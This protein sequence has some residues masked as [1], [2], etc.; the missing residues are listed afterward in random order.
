MT[1]TPSLDYIAL[2]DARFAA[3]L[4]SDNIIQPIESSA[5]PRTISYRA[6][7]EDGVASLDKGE[8]A[9]VGSAY[10]KIE[11]AGNYYFAIEADDSARLIIPAAGID[12]TK[13]SGKLNI[14]RAAVVTLEAGYYR[15][16]DIHVHNIDYSAGANAIAFKASMDTQPIPDGD[17]NGDSTFRRSFSTAPNMKLYALV[18]LGE[19]GIGRKEESDNSCKCGCS[20]KGGA[21]S[22]QASVGCARWDMNIGNFEDIAG[23]PNAQLRMRAF[24]LS[25]DELT[26]AALFLHHPMFSVLSVADGIATITRSSGDSVSYDVSTGLPTSGSGKHSSRSRLLDDRYAPLTEESPI[27]DAAYLEECFADS[28][29]LTY[30]IA[31]GQAERMLTSEQVLVTA[32]EWAARLELI[33]DV[34]DRLRQILDSTLGLLDITTSSATSYSIALYPTSQVGAKGLDGLYSTTGN[35]IKTST[36]NGV[37]DTSLSITE[38]EGQNPATH[39]NWT[40]DGNNWN[41]YRGTEN[42]GVDQAHAVQGLQPDLWRESDTWKDDEGN[43]IAATATTYRQAPYGQ[44]VVRETEGYGSEARHT[45]YHYGE[46]IEE[47][48]YG[49]LVRVDEPTGNYT[50]YEYDAEG[51]VVLAASPTA[52]SG[53]VE[54]GTR[55]TYAAISDRFNDHRPATVKDVLITASGTEVVMAIT[56]YSYEDSSSLHRVTISRSGTGVTGTRTTITESYGDSIGT[57]PAYARGQVKYEQN[58]LGIE[59]HHSYEASSAYGSVLKHTSETRISNAPVVGK[60][61]R[62]VEYLA[63]NRNVLRSETYAYTAANEWTLMSASTYSY[64]ERGRELSRTRS[65]GRVSTKTWMCCGLL[66]ETDEDGVTTLYNYDAAKRLIGTERSAT[67]TTP[68]TVTAYELD[69]ADRRI[70]TLVSVGARNTVTSKAYDTLGRVISETDVLGRVTDTAY[71]ADGLTTTTTMPAGATF[72]STVNPDGSMASESG[73]GQREIF[74]SYDINANRYRS[75]QK[76]SDN[77]VLSQSLTNTLG[78][79]VVEAAAT[80]SCFLYT[81]SEYNTLGQL[82]RRWQDSGSASRAATVYEYDAFGEISKETLLLDAGSPSDATKNLIRTL[83]SVYEKDAQNLVWKVRTQTRNNPA[84][85]WL[86]SSQRQ[87]VSE[88]ALLESSTSTTDERGQTST[89]TVAYDAQSSVT[90]LHTETIPTSNLPATATVVDGFTTSQTDHSGVTATYTRAFTSSGMTQ[91]STDGRGNTMTTLS[92]LADRIVCTTEAVNNTTTTTYD[93]YFDLPSVVTNAQG[94][95]TCYKYDLR[96]RKIAEWGTSIQ[97]ACFGYDDA[98]NLI[99]LTTF[100]VDTGDITTD[101]SERTDGDTTTWA[102]HPTAGVELSKTY[103]DNSQVTKTYNAFK[104]ISTET[105]ARGQVAT[106]YYEVSTGDLSSVFYNDGSTARLYTYNIL[107]QITQ[108]MD[109]SGLKNYS[110]NSYGQLTQETSIGFETGSAKEQT[111]TEIYDSLGRSTGYTLHTCNNEEQQVRIA[112]AADGRISSAGFMHGGVLKNFSYG[113]LTGTDLLHTLAH[114]NGITLTQSYETTRDLLTGMQYR[115]GQTDVASRSYTYDSL[116]RPTTRSTSRQG[117]V[118]NDTFTHNDR[119]ELT[120]TSLGTDAYSYSYDNIGNRKT[121]QED[122]EDAT[123]YTANNLNQYTS[124]QEGE[125]DPPFVPT[126]DADGNQTKVKTSTGIWTVTYNILNLPTSFIRTNGDGTQTKVTAAYDTYGRRVWKKVEQIAAD[127]LTST[128]QS[129][130]LFLYRGYLQIAALDLTTPSLQ[131]QHFILWDPS[132]PI[133]TRPLAIQKNATWYTYGWDLTKNVCEVFGPDGYL[134]TAYT[135]MP[136]GSVTANGNV[137]Q[138]LQWSSEYHDDTMDLV[139]FNYRFYNSKVGNWLSKDPQSSLNLYWYVGN[140]PIGYTDYLGR[141]YCISDF[142]RKIKLPRYKGAANAWPFCIDWDRGFSLEFCGDLKSGKIKG[143]FGYGFEVGITGGFMFRKRIW[144]YDIY[145][146]LGLRFFGGAS[147][148]VEI[149]GKYDWSSC[150][151]SI[152]ALAEGKV[153]LGAEIGAL[154]RVANRKGELVYE[155]GVG[156]KAT[157]NLQFGFSLE[158]VQQECHLKGYFRFSDTIDYSIFANFGW[159][160]VSHQGEIEVKK[161]EKKFL[162]DFYLPFELGRAC[163]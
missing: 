120:A 29:S 104:Q 96:G 133:A 5:G 149:E 47:P 4:I 31:G 68:A 125:L 41:W 159:F 118:K 69:S 112:Y 92:D 48:S 153:Y 45:D 6:Y 9:E 49:K 70:R 143:S 51:R 13:A 131:A 109:A 135:Y 84:G 78:D 17:Y 99:S 156:G 53:Y 27:S 63:S 39:W 140:H 81:K 37:L 11:T 98:D 73:T 7:V 90:R 26:P 132:Q 35:R 111:C 52:I 8:E 136:Y 20:C 89:R 42:V 138:P 38:Q 154:A 106:Y 22:T 145:G 126:Y 79:K 151:C 94:K 77:S 10:I 105:N 28:S 91:T 14:A 139:Y 44:V 161:T 36:F 130:Q 71:S 23:M 119:S 134:K 142:N 24:D 141:D 127:G 128:T 32:S 95:T 82:V 123:T 147:G 157:Y 117:T 113:Y 18:S 101:P 97:P 107:G 57:L 146:L 144:K 137:I 65:N 80:T 21:G 50:R 93:S 60:S 102:Y 100:R 30:P 2:N 62:S 160:D 108:A 114:P 72:I 110:Y 59:T 61:T 152:D 64:D 163:T 67:P 16:E 129:H 76:L 19:G 158:C 1:S 85:S 34:Q 103:A 121:A 33:F 58:E 124:I 3:Q 66:S 54:K 43:V 86:S 12:I 162:N 40:K 74:H 15:I 83:T 87:L 25:A 115:Q 148:E 75:T 56:T 116:G 88:S 150:S 155:I 46:A 55:T 122:A